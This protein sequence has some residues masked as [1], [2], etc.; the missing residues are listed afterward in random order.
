MY[1]AMSKMTFP[2]PVITAPPPTTP[3]HQSTT[4]TSAASTAP[5]AAPV[6]VAPFRFHVARGAS[7]LTISEAGLSL[8]LAILLIFAGSLTLRDSPTA[9]RL[10]RLY[11]VVKFPLIIVA[12]FATWWTY[13]TLM[14]GFN[15]QVAGAPG[16]VQMSGFT[17]MMAL[18]QAMIWAAVSMIYPIALLIV[19]S[20]RTS[21]DHLKRIRSGFA[22]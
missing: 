4:M 20:T 13:T 11:L 2:A 12:A 19:L 3:S 7:V 15:L 21:K 17:N 14:S 5:A 18:L 22:T 16:A 1:L 9:W 6:T 10:H 8:C